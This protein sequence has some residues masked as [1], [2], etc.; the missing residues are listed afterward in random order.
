[1]LIFEAQFTHISG[2]CSAA[3][4]VVFSDLAKYSNYN[5]FVRAVSRQI[6]TDS[7]NPNEELIGNFSSPFP[8]RTDQDGSDLN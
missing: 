5:I 3:D 7:E 2:L 8:I 6:Q 4:Q 1:M